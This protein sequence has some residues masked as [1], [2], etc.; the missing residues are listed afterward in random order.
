M[1]DV[2]GVDCEDCFSGWSSVRVERPPVA[3]QPS[4]AGRYGE[5]AQMSVELQINI[6]GPFVLG[7]RLPL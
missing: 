2:V 1:F 5:V 6:P 3:G 7:P 4:R